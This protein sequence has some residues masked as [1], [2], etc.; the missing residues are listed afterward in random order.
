MPDL[1]VYCH[2]PDAPLTDKLVRNALSKIYSDLVYVSSPSDEGRR[3]IQWSSYDAIDHSLLHAKR[4]SVLAS[5]YTFR[6]CLIR[7]HFLCAFLL[8]IPSC[9]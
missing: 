8:P 9:L 5:A 3:L 7:K 4:D 2:W 1:S 6:K